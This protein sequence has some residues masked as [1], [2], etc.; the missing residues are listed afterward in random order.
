MLMG[1]TTYS[2]GY[3]FAGNIGAILGY[4]SILSADDILV[5][6]EKLRRTYQI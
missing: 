5:N 1:S 4:T 2:P 3:S 6:F